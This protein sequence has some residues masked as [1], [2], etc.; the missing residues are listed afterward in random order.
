MTLLQ[1]FLK[2]TT[3]E[4]QR[5]RNVRLHAIGRIAELPEGCQR[6][7]HK[8]MEATAANTGLTLILALSYSGRVGDY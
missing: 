8:S 2:D 4:L 6:Q 7:L 3:P 5:Q 1:K